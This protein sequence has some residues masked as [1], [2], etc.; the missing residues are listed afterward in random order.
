M[1]FVYRFD[2][3]ESVS[4]DNGRTKEKHEESSIR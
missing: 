1:D 4:G 3:H 2:G